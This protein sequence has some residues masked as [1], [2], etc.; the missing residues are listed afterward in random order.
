MEVLSSTNWS[1]SAF[2]PDTYVQVSRYNI[3]AKK[4]ALLV[5]DNVIRPAPHP[6]SLISLDSLA[7]MRG[8]EIGYEYAE[9]FMTCWRDN[10]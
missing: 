1:Y 8:C 6:R 10:I 5:Y 2:K 7:T 4:N 9:A 3:D